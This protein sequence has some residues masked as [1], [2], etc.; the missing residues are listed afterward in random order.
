M[1]ALAF[2]SCSPRQSTL[3][4]PELWITPSSPAR[5]HDNTH[6]FNLRYCHGRTPRSAFVCL[7]GVPR[8]IEERRPNKRKQS[9]PMQMTD[10]ADASK[11]CILVVV[12]LTQTNQS[13]RHRCR[14]RNSSRRWVQSPAGNASDSGSLA[15]AVQRMAGRNRLICKE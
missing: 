13:G 1:L 14:S 8:S 7:V 9:K 15:A 6:T 3:V 5:W 10:H 4:C 11:A 12:V 2:I